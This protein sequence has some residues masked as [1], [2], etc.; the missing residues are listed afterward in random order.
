MADTKDIVAAITF[1]RR[2]G[3]MVEKA[4]MNVQNIG[5][6]SKKRQ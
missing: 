2:N 4:E 6:L 3:Y 5:K 1:L